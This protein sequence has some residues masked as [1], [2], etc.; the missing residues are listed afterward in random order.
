M[1]NINNNVYEPDGLFLK[2]IVLVA[3]GISWIIASIGLAGFFLFCA[4][5]VKIN[6]FRRKYEAFNLKEK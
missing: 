4:G 3:I 2:T 6:E 5:T 1:T